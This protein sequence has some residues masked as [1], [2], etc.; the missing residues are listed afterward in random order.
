MKTMF[1]ATMLTAAL[2]T[3]P[4]IA[5]QGPAGVPG[6]PGLAELGIQPTPLDLVAEGWLVEYRRHGR[7]GAAA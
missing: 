1:I 4:A 2:I 6:A 5:Q 7:F 3:V